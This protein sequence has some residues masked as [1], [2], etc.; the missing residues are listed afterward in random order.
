MIRDDTLL[1]KLIIQRYDDMH[2]PQRRNITFGCSH[3]T[4]VRSYYIMHDD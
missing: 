4:Y 2:G 3:T 1:V